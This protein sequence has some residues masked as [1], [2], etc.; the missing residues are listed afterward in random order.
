[1]KQLRDWVLSRWKLLLTLLVLVLVTGILLSY[2]LGSLVPGLSLE[3]QHYIQTQIS[4]RQILDFPIF[5]FHKLPIYVLFK[6][7]IHLISAYRAV[8][9][10]FAATM[11]LS[12]F[13]ILKRWYSQRIAI[14]GSLLLA[15]SALA[16]HLGRLATP[17]STFMLLL[18]LLATVLWMLSTHKRKLSLIILAALVAV[19]LYIPGFIWLMLSLCT[20]QRKN[21]L[22]AIKKTTWWIKAAGG[23]LILISALPLVL[24]SIHA[25]H[26]LLI[27]AGLPVHILSLRHIGN[28]IVSIPMQLFF[29]GPTDPARWLGQLPILDA[30]STVMLILGIYSLRYHLN[31][32]RFKLL[33]GTTLILTILIILGGI[34]LT[35]LVPIL[36]LLSAAG[37][38]FML[39]QW[40]TVFPRN[41]IARTLATGL[42]SMSVVSVMFYTSN[43]YFVAWP[44]SPQTVHVFNHK[45]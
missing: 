9:G 33:A 35:A 23:L 43:Q 13:F 28:N 40:F 1:M 19:S 27:A 41:P 12:G 5:V 18:P 38:A 7:H 2:R 17:D 36:Y 37:I 4:G 24:A 8:S 10:I 44:H 11:V 25:P 32:P 31:K 30:F 15:S 16:L 34:P 29:R 14:L 39:Q 42:V 6:L 22:S 3:E 20:W 21:L 26:I 45:L